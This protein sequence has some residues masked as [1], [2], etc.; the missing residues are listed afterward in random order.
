MPGCSRQYKFYNLKCGPIFYFGT[1]PRNAAYYNPQGN[2]LC[3]AGLSNL[4]GNF[5]FWDVKQKKLINTIKAMDTT[6]FCLCPDEEHFI[7]S[8]MAP[9]LRVGNGYKLW[10][11]SGSILAQVDTAC[12]Q[13]LWESLWFSDMGRKFPEKA[14]SYKKEPPTVATSKEAKPL[15]AYR[16]L[17]ARNQVSSISIKLHDF[18]PPS[19]MKIPEPDTSAVCTKNKR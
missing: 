3:Q 13:K 6:Y 9:R 15:A 14:V 8:T 16:L 1:G 18:R 19:N 17:L 12:G 5:Y 10:H 4:Q 7:T 2:I 11:Y